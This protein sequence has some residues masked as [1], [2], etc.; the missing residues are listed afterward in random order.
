MFSK[1]IKFTDYRGKEREKEYLFH[2]TEAECVE[3]QFGTIGGL[4]QLIKHIVEV[5][6][7]PEL[8]RIFKDVVLKAYG[9][10]SEDGERFEK[11]EEARIAFSQT[12]AYSIL[13]MELASDAKAAAK[14]FEGVIPKAANIKTVN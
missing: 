10:I 13:F 4:D 2:F 14:F 12:P 1:T 11:S 3:L 5:E 7:M 8:I 9:T 6:D